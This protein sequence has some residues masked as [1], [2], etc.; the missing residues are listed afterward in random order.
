M[1]EQQQEK[2]QKQKKKSLLQKGETTIKLQDTS[3]KLDLETRE[4]TLQKKGKKKRKKLVENVEMGTKSQ[5]N[6]KGI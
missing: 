3:N 5:A 1:L 6:Y 2:K 4:L